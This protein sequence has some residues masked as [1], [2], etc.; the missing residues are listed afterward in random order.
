MTRRV[1]EP[2]NRT[3]EKQRAPPGRITGDSASVSNLT[4]DPY[5]SVHRVIPPNLDRRL[6]TVEPTRD[7]NP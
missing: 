3:S 4:R 6:R 2:L 7:P 5:P 1:S